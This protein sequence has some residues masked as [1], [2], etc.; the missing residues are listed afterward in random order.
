MLMFC[1]RVAASPCTDGTM[2]T[3]HCAFG[4]SRSL[5]S[6]AALSVASRLQQF[7]G[8]EK[9]TSSLCG[10]SSDCH[11]ANCGWK[12]TQLG[13]MKPRSL[14]SLG[15]PSSSSMYVLLLP[16]AAWPHACLGFICHSRG[17]CRRG[18]NSA[19]DTTILMAYLGPDCCASFCW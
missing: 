9:P 17:C 1:S 10:S 14:G 2:C 7:V 4:S 19:L 15:H 5:A 6:S 12:Y 8:L 18:L 3:E 11:C 13:P 16:V